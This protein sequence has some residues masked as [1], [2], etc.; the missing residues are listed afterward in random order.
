MSR[1]LWT[2]DC[3]SRHWVFAIDAGEAR[4]MWMA[5]AQNEGWVAEAL[6]ALEMG[7][8]V[9]KADDNDTFTLLSDDF[10]GGQVKMTAKQWN[11]LYYNAKRVIDDINAGMLCP[12][13]PA[14]FF[15]TQS[16]WL[17]LAEKLHNNFYIACSEF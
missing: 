13:D 14:E 2:V 5:Q 9:E 12:L 1:K 7:I 15:F 10:A 17:S 3:G 11:K 4:S 8:E 16:T 6:E